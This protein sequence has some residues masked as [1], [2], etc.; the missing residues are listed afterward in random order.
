MGSETGG[1]GMGTLTGSITAAITGASSGLGRALALALARPGAV[2]HLSGRDAQRLE[3][4]VSAVRSAGATA[5]PT[6]LDVRDAEAVTDW[7]GC[8]GRLDLVIANAGISAGT[9]GGAAESPAQMRAI[10][11]TNLLGVL[12][13]VVPALARMRSQEP[14]ADGLRGRIAVIASI[15]AFVPA[16]GAPTYCAAKAAVDAW[17][18]ATAH[19][20]ARAGILLASVCPGYLRTPMTEANRFPMPGLMAAERAAAIILR[21]LARGRRRIVFPWWLGLAARSVGLLPARLATALLGSAEGKAPL[22]PACQS[23]TRRA[24][25]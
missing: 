10:I 23:G 6:L 25:P 5:V 21:G 15:A 7:I 13:T 9:A 11:E 16:P 22:D 4:T 24:G 17:T 12:H 20:A 2:L 1:S 19:G 14:G 18:V 3:A 8:A